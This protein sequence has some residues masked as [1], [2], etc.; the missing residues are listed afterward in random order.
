M[1]CLHCLLGEVCLTE[2]S[3]Y[4]RLPIFFIEPDFTSIKHFHEN[5]VILFFS[6]E[7]SR[8][9]MLLATLRNIQ[10]TEIECCVQYTLAINDCLADLVF[11]FQHLK[12]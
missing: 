12:L 8:N 2:E 4:Q 1:N 5:F 7:T 9:I 10:N 6:T 3:Y 11:V